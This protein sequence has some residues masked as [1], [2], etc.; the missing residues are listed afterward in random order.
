MIF[1]DS[2][3]SFVK[4]FLGLFFGCDV[5]ATYLF[6]LVAFALIFGFLSLLFVR[7]KFEG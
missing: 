1:I 7:R 4:F 6:G 2:F 3:Y 5:L